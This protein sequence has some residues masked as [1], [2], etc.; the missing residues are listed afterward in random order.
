MKNKP[1]LELRPYIPELM[2]D[3]V[4]RRVGVFVQHYGQNIRHWSIENMAMSIYLQAID[5]VLPLIEKKP[6][7]PIDYQ[8]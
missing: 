4:R 3:N 6:E 1:Q 7:P 8:I 2:L 5:D